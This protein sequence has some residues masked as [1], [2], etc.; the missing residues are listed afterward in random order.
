MARFRFLITEDPPGRTV[1]A[2]EDQGE[3]AMLAYATMGTVARRAHSARL[4]SAL[5]ASFAGSQDQ[6][7]WI[8]DF[9]PG[10]YVKVAGVWTL[11]ADL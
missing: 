5:L 2:P 9:D 8:P 4:A 7:E 10:L 3:A 6:S 1:V 11:T